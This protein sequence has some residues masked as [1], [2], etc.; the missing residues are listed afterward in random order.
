MFM[1]NYNL[2]LIYQILKK[3]IVFKGLI[4]VGM[5]FFLLLID[6]IKSQMIINNNWKGFSIEKKCVYFLFAIYIR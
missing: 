1:L 6:D 2:F 4:R 3:S 5:C